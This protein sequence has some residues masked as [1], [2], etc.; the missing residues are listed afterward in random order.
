MGFEQELRVS[1]RG[2]GRRLEFAV[3]VALWRVLGFEGDSEFGLNSQELFDNVVGFAVDAG[4]GV[5]VGGGVEVVGVG[6]VLFED[7]EEV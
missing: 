4:I 6:E 3:A 1:E 2:R 7:F 5:A